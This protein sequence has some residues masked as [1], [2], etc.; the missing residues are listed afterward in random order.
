MSY[1]SALPH[2]Y[3]RPPEAHEWWRATLPTVPVTADWER[4]IAL[5]ERVDEGV[6]LAVLR[7]RPQQSLELV[8][9]GAP[10]F[11]VQV[12]LAGAPRIALDDGPSCVA[13]PGELVMFAYPGEQGGVISLPADEDVHLV[14]AR[15]SADALSRIAP[16]SIAERLRARFEDAGSVAR[17]GGM[18]VSCTAS[19]PMLSLA[20]A[21]AAAPP[22]RDPLAASLWRR[23]CLQQ[24]FACVLDLL[25]DERTPS[26][27]NA[28]EQ[29]RV[30][31]ALVLLES[32]CAEAW[33]A[34]RL[35]AAVGVSEKKLR[36]GVHEH[37]GLTV[38]ALQRQYRLRAAATLLARGMSVT[39]AAAEVGY[40]NLSHFS[41]AFQQAY[42]IPPAR[43]ARGGA[44]ALVG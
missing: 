12:L 18:L 35:A 9:P 42:G 31:Q 7:G 2:R 16:F 1:S 30:A 41:K 4:T 8:T 14:D 37:C 34:A 11:G 3:D 36:V 20:R 25:A 28:R 27:L 44:S 29:Q 6:S 43:V 32:R 38:H 22:V 40:T 19:P 15:W 13:A 23:G 26:T 5:L 17:L 33:S 39:V 10:V 24:L 21:V